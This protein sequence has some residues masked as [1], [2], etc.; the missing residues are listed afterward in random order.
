MKSLYKLFI[1]YDGIEDEFNRR[2]CRNSFYFISNASDGIVT[3][4]IIAD[5]CDKWKDTFKG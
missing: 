5:R 2:F 3:I 4:G 1:K